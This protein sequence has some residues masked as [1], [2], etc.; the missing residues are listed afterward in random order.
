MEG[1]NS[2]FHKS[3]TGSA[4]CGAVGQGGQQGVRNPS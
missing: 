1:L 4:E 3:L 2:D